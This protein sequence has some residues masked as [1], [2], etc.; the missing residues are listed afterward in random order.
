M[1][2]NTIGMVT[3]CDSDGVNRAIGVNACSTCGGRAWLPITGL[4]RHQHNLKGLC[5]LWE[6]IIQHQQVQYLTER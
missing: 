2:V 3:S 4:C 6:V 5:K 1:V